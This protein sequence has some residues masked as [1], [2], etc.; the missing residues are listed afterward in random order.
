MEYEEK[1]FLRSK[2]LKRIG[3]TP[4]EDR[5]T[6]GPVAIIECPQLIPCN[7]CETSCPNGAIRIGSAITN[8]PSLDW[9]KCSGCGSCVHQCPGLAVFIVDF[10]NGLVGIPFEFY[11]LPKI[12]EEVLC[13]DRRGRI[14]CRGTVSKVMLSRLQDRTAVVYVKI[15]KKFV[16]EIRGIKKVSEGDD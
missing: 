5:M 16:M 14:R 3:A 12:G 11:P 15:A 6:K 10:K 13:L 8:I 9:N 7:P 2:E 4:P 1:G